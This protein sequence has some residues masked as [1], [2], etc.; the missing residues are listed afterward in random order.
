MDRFGLFWGS[1][2]LLLG[3]FGQFRSPF[4][5]FDWFRLVFGQFRSP[6]ES[7]WSVYIF[8][9]SFLGLFGSI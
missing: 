5:W 4:G 3:C 8:F 7:C 9:G 6:F 1:L 2:S